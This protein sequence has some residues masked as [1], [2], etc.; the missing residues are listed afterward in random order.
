[1]ISLSDSLRVQ[2]FV[3]GVNPIAQSNWL[4]VWF[5]VWQTGCLTHLL[6]DWITESSIYPFHSMPFHFVYSLSDSLIRQSFDGLLAKRLWLLACFCD[7]VCFDSFIAMFRLAESWIS[8]LFDWFEQL[9]VYVCVTW[10]PAPVP[11]T[12]LPVSLRLRKNPQISKKVTRNTQINRTPKARQS[13]YIYQ[14]WNWIHLWPVGKGVFFFQSKQPLQITSITMYI[15]LNGLR[16]TPGTSTNGVPKSN[17]SWHKKVDLL[18]VRPHLKHCWPDGQARVRVHQ[19][20]HFLVFSFHQ[21][22]GRWKQNIKWLIWHPFMCEIWFQSQSKT[23]F[24]KLRHR[25]I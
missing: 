25:G 3:E 12:P 14:L 10:S 16:S 4:L 20:L 21:F 13:P 1:M 2:M 15:H 17:R 5:A 11:G 7:C 8:G 19:S 6:S 23:A 18:S 24:G 22:S 9:A